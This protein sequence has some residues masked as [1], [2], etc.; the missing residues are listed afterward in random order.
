[1]LEYN[2]YDTS[3]KNIYLQGITL[4]GFLAKQ[5]RRSRDKWQ[6]EFHIKGVLYQDKLVALYEN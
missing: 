6:P 1:M 3:K 2:K 4:Q 5:K